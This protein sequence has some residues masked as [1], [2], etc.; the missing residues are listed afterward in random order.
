MLL[1]LVAF[2]SN[3]MWWGIFLITGIK[4]VY[5]PFDLIVSTGCLASVWFGRYFQK[6]ARRHRERISSRCE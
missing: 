3:F 6:P 2:A 5:Y 4:T 1:S